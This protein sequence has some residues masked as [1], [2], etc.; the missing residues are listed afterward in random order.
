MVL[1]GF[2][3]AAVTGIN[4]LHEPNRLQGEGEG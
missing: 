3:G 4:Q 2:H 1:N